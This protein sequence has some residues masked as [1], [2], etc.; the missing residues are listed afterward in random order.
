M[1]FFP[2]DDPFKLVRRVCFLLLV[3]GQVSGLTC[4][5][6][7]V[8]AAERQVFLYRDGSGALVHD[9]ANRW[10][11]IVGTSEK[12]AFEEVAR[13]AD[14]IEFLDRGRDVGLKV[15]GTQGVI[16]FPGSQVWKP[17][18]AG[19]WVG[20]DEL[21]KSMVFVPTDQFIRLIYFV[22]ADRAPLADYEQRIRVVMRIVADQYRA[23][24][25]AHGYHSDGFRLELNDQQET[26]VHLVKTTNSAQ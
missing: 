2:L 20:I 7:K 14:L 10:V 4:G 24:L 17:W 1:A 25:A 15:Q 23:E 8:L 12:F 11:E 16:R 26:R 13:T 19:Q 3:F 6:T 21:P 22:P 9:Y 5:N 18:Q